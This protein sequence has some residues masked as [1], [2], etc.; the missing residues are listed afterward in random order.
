MVKIKIDAPQ[1]AS[2]CAGASVLPVN[3]HAALE[4]NAI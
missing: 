3:N 2:S 1:P 4:I